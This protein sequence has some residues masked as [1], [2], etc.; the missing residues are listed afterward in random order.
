MPPVAIMEHWGDRATLGNTIQRFIA[1]R[2]AAGLPPETSPTFTVFRSERNPAVP[3]EYSIDICVGTSRSR[4][5][6]SR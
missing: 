2:K 5:M 3:A 6:T 1:W 4:R